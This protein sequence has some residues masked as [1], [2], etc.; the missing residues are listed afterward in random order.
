MGHPSMGALFEEPEG[1]GS[2]ARALKVMK[3]RLWGWASLMGLSIKSF[4]QHT[5]ICPII[6]SGY[7]FQPHGPSSGL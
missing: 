7:M 1:G 6:I 5:F 3:E 2:F 4:S